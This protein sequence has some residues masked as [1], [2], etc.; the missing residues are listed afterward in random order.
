MTMYREEGLV[1]V[2]YSFAAPLHLLLHLLDNTPMHVSTKTIVFGMPPFTNLI[3]LSQLTYPW[4]NHLPRTKQRLHLL[5]G[6]SREVRSHTAIGLQHAKKAI[7]L[8]SR[9]F[10]P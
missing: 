4:I 3:P 1:T 7:I 8:L 10:K 6:P 5:G 9:E 2:R